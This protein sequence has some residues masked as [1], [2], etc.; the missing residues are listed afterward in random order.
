[1]STVALCMIVANAAGTLPR[2]LESVAGSVDAIYITDTGSVDATTETARQFGATLRHFAWGDDFALARNASI[3]DVPED[4]ILCLDADDFFPA[5][6]A[7]KFRAVLH[8]D[9]IAFT[10]DY[11]I[12]GGCTPVPGLKLFRNHLG[13]R[14]EGIIHEYIRN[15]L[16]SI[17]NAR[18][19]HLPIQLMH[20][21]YSGDLPRAKAARNLPLLEREVARAEAVGD[22]AQ[23]LYAGNSLATT[24]LELNRPA[25]AK[26][27]LQSLLPRVVQLGRKC[28]D[29]WEIT[30]LGNLTSLHLHAREAAE[31]L[32]LCREYRGL[33]AG[34]PL[35]HFYSG[36]AY[37]HSGQFQEALDDFGRFERS[38]R[39]KPARVSI[40]QNL[41]EE[42]AWK[43]QGQCLL[44]LHEFE[45]A[46]LAFARCCQAN[47]DNPEYAARLQVTQLLGGRAPLSH[48]HS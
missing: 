17:P 32:A 23:L 18:I 43:W 26:T 19:E 44:Q 16:R 7:A 29:D 42:E 35:F 1:M 3:H 10:F 36:L 22:P 39:A 12:M 34:H 13:I 46:A 27:L 14:Y 2:C 8:R 33:F 30:I 4:W 15:S 20:S 21:G 38:W 45:Q 25:E 9:A 24:L 6:E 48:G 5:D 37:F 47:P 31:A 11:Y 40:P 41:P 28:D